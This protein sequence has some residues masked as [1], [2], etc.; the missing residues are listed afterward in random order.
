MARKGT[1]NKSFCLKDDAPGPSFPYLQGAAST[2]FWILRGRPQASAPY[3]LSFLDKKPKPFEYIRRLNHKD[4][5]VT[6]FLKLRWAFLALLVGGT[7]WMGWLGLDVPMSYKPAQ[8]LPARD[9]AWA[10]Y[11]KLRKNFG[12]DAGVI[13]LGARLPQFFEKNFF[14][15]FWVFCDSL[16][17]IPGVGRVMALPRAP[18]PLRNDSLKKFDLQPLVPRLP[19]TAEE[20]SRLR[21]NMETV[22]FYDGLL[23]NIRENVFMVLV[24]IDQKIL[25]T[26]ARMNTVKK[27]E[28][29]VRNFEAQ[30]GTT[31]HISGMPY[32]RTITNIRARREIGLFIVLAALVTAVVLAILFRSWPEV[33]IPLLNVGLSV[34]W[35]R[36]LMHLLGYEITLL[37][38][39]LPPLLIVIGIPNAVYLITKYHI[40][41]GRTP[42]KIKALE[43]V[44][45]RTGSA[46]FL[47]N[48]T[49]AVGFL[50]FAVTGSASLVEFGILAA[51]NV[52]LLFVLTLVF[53]PVAFSFLPRPSARSTAHLEKRLSQATVRNL[54]LISQYRRGWVYG[55]VL[56]ALGLSV[57]GI[58]R[59]HVEGTVTDDLPRH[60]PAI[61]D[62]RFFERYFGGVMPLEILIETQ[63]ENGFWKSPK[64]W[65]KMEA[66]QDYLKELGMTSRAFSLV[67]LIKFA[68]QAFYNGNPDYYQLPNQ[69]DRAF[70]VDYLKPGNGRDPW[71]NNFVD[72]S[73]RLTRVSV[74]LADLKA[75]DVL[76][77]QQKIQTYLNEAFPAESY[78]TAVTGG[79]VIF[80]HGSGYLIRNLVYS[81]V[82]AI[83]VISVLMALL[84]KK[85]K[86]VLISLVPNM[87]PLLFTAGLMG[88]AG[89]PLKPSTILVFGIAF[90]IA[91]DDT[92]HFLTKYRQEIKT[93]KNART[94]VVIALR[95]TGLSMAY[96]SIILF[97]G[98]SVFIWSDFGGTKALGMLVS[99]TLLSAMI[100]NLFL[101]PALLMSAHVLKGIQIWKPRSRKLKTRHAAKRLPGEGG[102]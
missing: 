84:F 79:S 23:W 53:I 2:I 19:E 86:M 55:L 22:V 70:L 100:T 54:I 88:V 74:Q 67:D 76:S 57:L 37:T 63:Q 28:E 44:V 13:V 65:K 10:D 14:R 51:L 41:C 31:W 81:M 48:L 87:L 34:V 33:L 27:L 47:T 99:F 6:R 17:S 15:S 40:E 83:T 25:N 97:F 7:A 5:Q 18:V 80:A 94:A 20:L 11:D 72:S 71:M 49:T 8:I 102:T 82:L 93:S 21:K 36:G 16:D 89:I 85:V 98:F 56:L 4:V 32:I 58:T 101:L 78:A 39:L 42:D 43:K 90:G 52:A 61:T 12:E 69:F 73:G 45:R 91:V 29:K 62:L 68:N 59:M 50:S 75:A 92:I 1:E 95:E 66:L 46:V 24:Q 77:L 9:S 3:R 35:S 38:G 64:L 60:D 30:T 26:A 96:T